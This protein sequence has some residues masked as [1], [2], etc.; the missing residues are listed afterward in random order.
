MRPSQ[1]ESTSPGRQPTVVS[2]NGIVATTG[3]RRQA[4]DHA[5]TKTEIDDS[6]NHSDPMIRTHASG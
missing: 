4:I 3:R 6:E 2:D 1:C 5:P